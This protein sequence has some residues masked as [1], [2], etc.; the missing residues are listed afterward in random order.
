MPMKKGCKLQSI[1]FFTIKAVLAAAHFSRLLG[2]CAPKV[3][4]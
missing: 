2:F 1:F 3:L 4:Q